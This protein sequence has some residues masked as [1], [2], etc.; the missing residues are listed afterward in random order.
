MTLVVLEYAQLGNG[1]S[2]QCFTGRH[3]IRKVTE[4]EST[5]LVEGQVSILKVDNIIKID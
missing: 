3:S 2:G 5:E 1:I 4:Q